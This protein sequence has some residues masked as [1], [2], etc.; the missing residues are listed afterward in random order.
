MAF[1]V[2]QVACLLPAF[3][4]H[5]WSWFKPGINEKERMSLRDV[6]QYKCIAKQNDE[7]I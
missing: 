6:I 3:S 2:V 1:G 7:T 4:H 5:T